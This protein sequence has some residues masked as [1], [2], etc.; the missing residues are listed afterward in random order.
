MI[1]TYQFYDK[2]Q[3]NKNKKKMPKKYM[4]AFNNIF[5]ELAIVLLSYC[6]EEATGFDVKASFSSRLKKRMG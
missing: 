4:K 6:F 3:K 5:Y 2:K 1:K